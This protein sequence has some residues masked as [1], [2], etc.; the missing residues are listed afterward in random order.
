MVHYLNGSIVTYLLLD[1][2]FQSIY[3]PVVIQSQYCYY[4]SLT[5]SIVLVDNTQIGNVIYE[6]YL[7]GGGGIN[8]IVFPKNSNSTFIKAMTFFITN[9]Q[10]ITFQSDTCNNQL[11]YFTNNYTCKMCNY[12][13][14]QCSGLDNCLKCSSI[15]FTLMNSYCCLPNQFVYVAVVLGV[16]SKSCI[17]CT[18]PCIVCNNLICL[19]CDVGF[20]LIN[21]GCVSNI[22]NSSNSSNGT[23]FIDT[24]VVSN[25]LLDSLRH[26][27]LIDAIN[28]VPSIRSILKPILASFM[29]FDDLYLYQ[30]HERD[31]G[32][33]MNSLFEYI[34]SL[35]VQKW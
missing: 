22:T 20:N 30:F 8:N 4:D 9:F 21:N 23:Y 31:Y 15:N 16:I 2:S 24:L 33:T 11:D 14:A 3:G 5:E 26:N 34:S 28:R 25:L 18:L 19:Q 29:C 6:Q 12:G 1:F 35:E 32:N 10:I 27:Y 13:C 17:N 7:L